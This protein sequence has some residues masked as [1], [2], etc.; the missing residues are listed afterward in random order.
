[1]N[2]V[3][4]KF[5]ASETKTSIETCTRAR[6]NRVWVGSSAKSKNPAWIVD[7]VTVYRNEKSDQT[8]TTAFFGEMKLLRSPIADR[9]IHTC[10]ILEKPRIRRLVW[11]RVQEAEL[12]RSK[13]NWFCLP[14]HMVHL[15]SRHRAC[16]N[17]LQSH[18]W[19]RK[20]KCQRNLLQNKSEVDFFKKN[21]SRSLSFEK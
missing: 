17:P 21:R 5:G 16:R 4:W 18:L 14:H 8:W 6:F 13:I 11:R 12:C 7:V 19:Y 9:I 20:L 15:R 2:N 3:R 10:S 1:M